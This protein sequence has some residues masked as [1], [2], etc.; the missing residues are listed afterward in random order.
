MQIYSK[1]FSFILILFFVSCSSEEESIKPI[2]DISK[3]EKLFQHTAEFDQKIISYSGG[4]H[5]AIGFGIANAYL[6][7]GEGG[8][9]IIDTT[10]STFQAEKV[11]AEFQK[12]SNQPIAAIIYTHNHGDHVFGAKTFFNSQQEPPIVIAHDTMHKN[13]EKIVGL[14]NPIISDRSSKMFGT[15]LEE[16]LVNVGIGPYLSVGMSAPGYIK[17]SLTF[18][19]DLKVEIAGISLEL[20]HAPGETDDQLAVWIPSKSAIFVGDNLYKTFPNLY[21]IRGTSHR[22]VKKWSQSV[23]KIQ[24]YQAS[25]LFP[26]HTLPIIGKDKVLEITRLYADGIQYVH[27]QTVRLLNKGLSPQ[28]IEDTLEFPEIF[29]NSPYFYEFYGTVR[30]SIRSIFNGYLGWF[31]GNIATLDPLSSIQRANKISDL[32]GGPQNLL[33]AMQQAVQQEDYQWALE[34]SDLLLTLEFNTKQVNALR[35][36][37]ATNLAQIESNPNK[38]NYLLSAAMDLKGEFTDASKLVQRS[39]DILEELDLEMFI[40]VLQVNLNPQ[41]LS[42]SEKV[43]LCIEFTNGESLNLLVENFVLKEGDKNHC[44]SKIKLSESNFKKLLSGAINPITF[45]ASDEVETDRASEALQF[46]SLFRN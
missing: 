35:A 42:P 15:Q 28:E 4:I 16:D 13:V 26:S 30:W 9:I 14:I 31:D 34:L 1:Y 20:F 6:I 41:K 33:V 11:L 32:V 37:V 46:L 8:N 5:L 44:S 12:I 39:P 24:N 17:P 23:R 27:D 36:E 45:F 21:T 22:D 7:E 19:K 38:R 10:D 25:Y 40:S 18:S 43:S 29:T 2:P 3:V